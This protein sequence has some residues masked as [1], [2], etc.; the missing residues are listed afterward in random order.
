MEG[1]LMFGCSVVEDPPQKV[2]KIELVCL[3]T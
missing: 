3:K 1:D 2:I